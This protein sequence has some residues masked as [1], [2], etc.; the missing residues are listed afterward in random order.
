[1][2]IYETQCKDCGNVEDV[3]VRSWKSE[4]PNCSCGGS[5]VKLI[6]TPSFMFAQHGGTDKGR[7][8]QVNPKKRT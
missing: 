3:L 4:L 1:M 2:P 6:S 7:V 8:M 5:T